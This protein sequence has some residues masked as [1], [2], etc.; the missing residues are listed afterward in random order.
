MTNPRVSVLRTY[1]TGFVT[2]ERS[3]PSILSWNPGFGANLRSRAENQINKYLPSA[4]CIS[5]TGRE[6]KE[7]RHDPRSQKTWSGRWC[8]RE[9]PGNRHFSQ[10]FKRV[11]NIQG[12]W[13][14]GQRNGTHSVLLLKSFRASYYFKLMRGGRVGGGPTG[15][16]SY[17]QMNTLTLLFFFLILLDWVAVLQR[18]PIFLFT[19]CFI[20]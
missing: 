19:T 15:R 11:G 18:F 17:N 5:S 9:N 1:T 16:R 13:D 6:C 12:V 10:H 7:I 14:Y 4:Y 20:S 2:Q 8:K 3:G